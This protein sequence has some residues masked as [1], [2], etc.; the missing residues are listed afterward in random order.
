MGLLPEP[1]VGATW[2]LRP[3]HRELGIESWASR[4]GIET[5]ARDLGKV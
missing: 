3:G 4:A 2:A 1:E 5:W